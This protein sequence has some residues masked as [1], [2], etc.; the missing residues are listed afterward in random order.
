MSGPDSVQIMTSLADL[1]SRHIAIQKAYLVSCVNA[2]LSDLEAAAKVVAG[3]RVAPEVQFYVAPASHAV[4]TAAERSGVWRTLLDAGAIPLP[5]GCGPCIGLG[6]GVLEPGEVGI[7]ATNRNFKGRMGD[8]DAQCYLAN[9]AVVAASAVAGYITSPG[10]AAPKRRSDAIARRWRPRVV[11]EKV[12][13]LPGFP[14]EVH[15]RLVYLPQDN[16]N[17]DG[18]YGREHT[19]R[20]DVTPELMAQVVM[21]NYDPQFVERA[22]RGDIVVGGFNFGSGSS[23]EQAVT[24]LAAKGIALV[25]A[26][27]YSQTYLRN[28]FNNGFVCVEVPE[29]VRRLQEIFSDEAAEARTII[30]ADSLSID[31]TTG[32]LAYRGESYSF[33]PLGTV[34]QSLVI[35]GGVENLVSQ[36]LG[37]TR[38]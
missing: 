26:G 29:F 2:R 38:R 17:T 25:I 19:Y 16:L 33:P 37:L 8:R 28:A 9:P 14:S 18:I 31:F 30:P 34:P 4:Q 32:T 5:A 11:V 3:K 1:Q 23:R 36:R 24:A 21:Q 35:A 12:E 7:S 15:G 20:D 10:S 27:S 13:I 22:Q 6:A